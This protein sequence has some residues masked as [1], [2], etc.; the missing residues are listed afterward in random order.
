MT[1]DDGLILAAI[2][3]LGSEREAAQAQHVPAAALLDYTMRALPDTEAAGVIEHLAAC[4]ECGR[5]ALELGAWLDAAS[6]PDARLN[7]DARRV[8]ARLVRQGA[9][10]EERG[11][12]LGA[13]PARLW[14]AITAGLSA[15]LVAWLVWP[16]A[17][18]RSASSVRAAAVAVDLVPDDSDRARG[19]AELL[20]L[21]A[22]SE[23]VVLLL[24]PPARGQAGD[25]WLELVDEHERR[26]W[27]GWVARPDA[28][29]PMVLDVPARLLP[30]G[31]W[32]VRLRQSDQPASRTLAVYTL[33]IDYR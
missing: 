26:A 31:R 33:R 2:R 32:L 18:W 1:T 16:L 19:G 22:T 25:T 20:Q 9:Q 14:L 28:I 30:A 17:G 7:A 29:T 24:T 23:H 10:A 8:W 13:T 11:R 5:A 27:A 15:A 12:R 21:P 4:R 6:T 3:T